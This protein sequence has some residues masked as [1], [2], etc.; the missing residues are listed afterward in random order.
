M[1]QIQI[2]TN[3]IKTFSLCKL[4]VQDLQIDTRD[5]QTYMKLI[6]YLQTYFEWHYVYDYQ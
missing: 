3:T 5:K 4:P 6:V 1:T 2:L